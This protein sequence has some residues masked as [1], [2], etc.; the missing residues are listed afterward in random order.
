MNWNF[1]A[2]DFTLRLPVTDQD[3]DALYGLLSQQSVVDHIPRQAMTVSAQAMD[4][5]RRVAMRFET[6]EAAFWLVE[7]AAGQLLARLGIQRINWMQLAAQLQWE[8]SA[9]AT[10]PVLQQVMP[11]VE[12][13]VFNELGLHRLEMRV[14]EDSA[15][16]ETLLQ[17]LGFSREG[18]LPAQQ[19]YEG[20]MISYSLWSR[21]ATD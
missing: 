15:A 19:E 18:V 16:H 10:L 1:S 8:L 3:V 14:R 21:L 4:E 9:Q 7:N 12:H 2:G 17:A 11:A 13:F 6:R 5:L 20:D